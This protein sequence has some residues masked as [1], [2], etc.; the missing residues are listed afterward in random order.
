MKNKNMNLGEGRCCKLLINL[1]VPAIVVMVRSLLYNIVDRI[2]IGRM[3]NGE[4]AMAGVGVAFPIIM[5]VSAFSD[6]IGMGGAPLTAIKMGEK[7]NEDAE[8]IMSNSFYV[9]KVY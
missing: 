7:N 2:F 8:K 9:I 1:A 4:I 6:L 3:T 5:I